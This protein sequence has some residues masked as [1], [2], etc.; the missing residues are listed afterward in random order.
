MTSIINVLM[1]LFMIIGLFK[2][3]ISVIIAII[4]CCVS[5][6]CF[7]KSLDR[8]SNANGPIERQKAISN[9]IFNGISIVVI[10]LIAFFN[11]IIYNFKLVLIF[12]AIGLILKL[13]KRK[14]K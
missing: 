6:Y 3:N 11:I 9:I 5:I 8:L 7:C 1:A 13:L 14:S 4:F 10:L 2:G 12:V